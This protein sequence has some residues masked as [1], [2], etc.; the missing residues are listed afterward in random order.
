MNFRPEN[1]VKIY[2]SPVKQYFQSTASLLELS[3]EQ[4]VDSYGRSVTLQ[5]APIQKHTPHY[6]RV[7]LNPSW[8]KDFFQRK[9]HCD[10]QRTLQSLN[11]IKHAEDNPTDTWPFST[12][13][14]YLRQE[15][16]DINTYGIRSETL[17]NIPPNNTFRKLFNLQTVSH[18]YEDVVKQE[19]KSLENYSK[20]EP[21]VAPF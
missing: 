7:S 5:E 18:G 10:R 1:P 12:Y 11:R 6:I 14:G 21:V 9:D 17:G 16:F 20:K 15:I 2:G 3:L 13:D 4:N 19:E 8:Y